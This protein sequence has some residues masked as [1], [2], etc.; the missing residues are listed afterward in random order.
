MTKSSLSNNRPFRTM[1]ENERLP[2]AA[3]GTGPA[4]QV[5]AAAR[6]CLR[7]FERGAG[8]AAGAHGSVCVEDRVSP[9][10]H[11]ARHSLQ[12]AEGA[13]A[14]DGSLAELDFEHGRT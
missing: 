9:G 4:L 14:S 10:R 6:Y 1:R 3:R 7:D 13:P 8:A 2:A 12:S 5:A 11:S